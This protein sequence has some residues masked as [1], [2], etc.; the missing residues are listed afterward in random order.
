[1]KTSSCKAKGR[2]ACKKV[3]ALILAAFPHLKEDDV[4][5]TPSGVTGEDIQLSTAAREVLPV[6][7]EVKCQ[8]ALNIWASLEQAKSHCESTDRIPL[9]FFTR[10][11]AN[12]YVALEA[13]IFLDIVRKIGEVMKEPAL[14]Q[15]GISN[16]RDHA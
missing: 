16:G 4:R 8:E 15:T 13:D 11:R 12:L 9:L 7:I 5:I 1:M 3:Q 6:A 10:N 14:K 2:N